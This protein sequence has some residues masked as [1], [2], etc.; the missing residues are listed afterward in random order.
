MTTEAPVTHTT[1]NVFGEEFRLRGT[2]S[3]DAIKAIARHVDAQIRLLASRNPRL[4]LHRLALLTALNI[5]EEV[6]RVESHY[7]ELNAALQKQW[8]SLKEA[9]PQVKGAKPS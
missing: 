8:R 1:V 9:A 5:A 3:E 6:V 2:L 4:P 7:E